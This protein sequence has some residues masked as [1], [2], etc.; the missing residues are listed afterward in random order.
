MT[1]ICLKI[2]TLTWKRKEDKKE[3][4]NVGSEDKMCSGSEK[5]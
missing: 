5:D 4:G 2:V 3:V 1:G